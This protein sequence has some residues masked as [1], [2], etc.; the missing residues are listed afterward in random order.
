MVFET[1]FNYLRKVNAEEFAALPSFLKIGI[2]I[3]VL[4]EALLFFGTSSSGDRAFK[5]TLDSL[6]TSQSKL[7]FEKLEKKYEKFVQN[8]L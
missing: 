7:R 4:N 1:K 3:K 5:F 6:D 8:N 2:N